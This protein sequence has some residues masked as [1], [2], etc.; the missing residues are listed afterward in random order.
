MFVKSLCL[1]FCAVF[2]CCFFF[3]ICFFVLEFDV[4]L[5]VFGLLMATINRRARYYS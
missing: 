5:L 3:F 2:C 4:C 1:L